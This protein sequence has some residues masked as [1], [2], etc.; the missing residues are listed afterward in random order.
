MEL[1]VGYLSLTF[2]CVTSGKT[3]FACGIA[4]QYADLG[5]SVLYVNTHLDNRKTD[6]GQDNKFTSHSSSNRYLTDKVATIRVSS[7][8]DFS[9]YRLYDVIVIDEGQ[10]Y[11]DLVEVVMELV[12]GLG[13][14]VEV[15]GLDGDFQRRPFGR[16]A[17]LIPKA[18]TV[19]KLNARCSLCVTTGLSFNDVSCLHKQAPFSKKISGGDDQIDIGGSDKYIAVCRY[20]YLNEK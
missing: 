19:R 5:A 7:L 15:V 2:G 10:F 11:S 8:K 9:D 14:H 16:I 18:D 4:T 3:R 13:K 12:D 1:K 6:G 20:H 17:E